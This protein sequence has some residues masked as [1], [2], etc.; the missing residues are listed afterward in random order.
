[1][2]G[3]TLLLLF[4]FTTLLQFPP[5][6]PSSMPFPPKDPA[7]LTRSTKSTPSGSDPFQDLLKAFDQWDDQVGCAQFRDTHKGVLKNAT[8]SSSSLQDADF[9]SGLKCDELTM[10]HVSVLVKGWTWIPD[11]LDNLY[12][13]KC[14]M[15]CLWTKS[16]V[17]ADKPDALFFE[18]STPPLQR[19]RGDPLRVYMDLE[20]GRKRSAY[21][22]IFVSYHAKDDVQSTYAGA[23]FH[24]NRNFQLSP[25]KRND[26]LVYWSSSRCL[27]ERN[28][29]ARS[30]LGLLPHH[31]FGKCLNNVGGMDMAL[32]YYP[33]CIKDANASPK[34]WDHL[35][36][37][38]SH[39]KFVLAIENTVT[40]SYVTEKL[41]YA[42]DS[43]SVPIYFGA[44]NVWDFVP[45]H[46]IIDGSKFSSM[47]EL[48]SYVK[49][50]AN[51]PVA[52]A[53]YH[54]WRRCGVLGNYGKAR[55][56][57]LDTLPCRLCEAVSRKDGR[58]AA[59]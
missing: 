10:K 20:A 24:N 43:G 52:Y 51:D 30:I 39:Y 15:S 59:L 34:W 37:A 27:P 28:K 32:S 29:L 22:D 31:S 53:E 48:A 25:L 5:A 41:F 7:F 36:C 23:L 26:T 35:H 55:A 1:M 58:N 12:Y 49:A 40:E 45:P 21:E 19:R 42:L 18:T 50:V 9:G 14:G 2:L 33:Q 4:S 54:A 16:P 3:F 17:L 57:S 13:C 56:V 6:S 11:N 38:V 47:Q 46:S 8:F 44:P